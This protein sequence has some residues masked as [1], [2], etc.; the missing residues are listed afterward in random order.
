VAEI[1]PSDDLQRI[2][3]L[4]DAVFDSSKAEE[5]L[6][7]IAENRTSEATATRDTGRELRLR[8]FSLDIILDANAILKDLHFLT[9]RRENPNART[10]LQ[11][12][13]DAGTVEVYAPDHLEE[14]ICDEIPEMS[15]KKDI[16]EEDLWDMWEEL[17]SQIEFKEVDDG[18][19]R[20]AARQAKGTD[21]PEVSYD[22]DDLPYVGLHL[23]TGAPIHSED[24]HIEKMGAPALDREVMMRL[25]NYSRE[26]SFG[27]HVIY[28]QAVVTVAALKTAHLLAKGIAGLFQ[29]IWRLPPVFKVILGGL[30]LLVVLHPKSRQA[31]SEKLAPLL[32]GAGVR[33]KQAA[34]QVIFPLLVQGYGASERAEEEL[35]T[36]LDQIGNTQSA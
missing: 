14:E 23:Q 27:Y 28:G 25:R 13:I 8:P 30:F 36:A 1:F 9:K 21:D 6:N 5:A 3:N 34:V 17:R 10:A 20:L 29:K 31:I 4:A 15:E 7:R 18:K 26:A 35:Q 24:Q 19:L 11:E 16:P 12:V 32:K 22:T 33:T 2:R